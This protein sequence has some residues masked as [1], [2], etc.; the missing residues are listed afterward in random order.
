MYRGVSGRIMAQPRLA[1]AMSAASI[2][3]FLWLFPPYRELALHN[4]GVPLNGSCILGCAYDEVT[5]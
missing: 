5:L 2:S 4:L 3:L 1:W